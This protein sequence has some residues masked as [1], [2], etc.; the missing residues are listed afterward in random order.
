MQ[1]FISIVF[2]VVIG[3][4]ALGLTANP[5][6]AAVTWDFVGGELRGASGVDVGGTLYDVE[7]LN[8]SC[9]TVFSGCDSL[10]AS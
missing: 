6:R 7:F 2:T 4:A 3:L 1:K 9:E 8:A 10:A 5:S